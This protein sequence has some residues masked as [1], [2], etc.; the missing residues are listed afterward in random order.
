MPTTAEQRTNGA[1]PAAAPA[2]QE[3]PEKQANITIE[4]TPTGLHVRA[5]YTGGLSS[6][7]RAIEQLRAA[8]VLELVQA[9]APAQAVPQTKAKAPRVQPVYNDAGEPCCPV[10]GRVLSEGQY[11]LYCRSKASA[12]EAANDKG[13]CALK[14]KE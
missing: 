5:E 12:G 10:H 9:S 3:R 14:F 1:A 7:P 6:I 11:G 13:Y 4:V 8:G 2:E